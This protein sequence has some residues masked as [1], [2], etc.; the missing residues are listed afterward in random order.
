MIFPCY[1]YI[2]LL[3]VYGRI[4]AIGVLRVPLLEVMAY[5]GV[6]VHPW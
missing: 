2:P 1:R 6:M 4:D 3:V 5:L